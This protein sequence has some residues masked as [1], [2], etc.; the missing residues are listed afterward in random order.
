MVAPNYKEESFLK[1]ERFLQHQKIDR[2]SNFRFIDDNSAPTRRVIPD[3]SSL[4][5]NE[6][7]KENEEKKDKD[8]FNKKEKV[9]EKATSPS[10]AHFKECA[11]LSAENTSLSLPL[12]PLKVL[13]NSKRE[14]IEVVLVE[15]GRGKIAGMN[16]EFSLLEDLHALFHFTSKDSLKDDIMDFAS[17]AVNELHAG[18]KDKTGKPERYG[19]YYFFNKLRKKYLQEYPKE[20]FEH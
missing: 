8:N 7:D 14:K 15:N 10:T 18:K 2:P 5:E 11:S 3:G 19:W 12:V 1:V 20:Y 16:E 17:N 9:A 13:L 4:K 6:E